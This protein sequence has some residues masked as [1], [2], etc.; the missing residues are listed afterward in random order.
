MAY[1]DHELAIIGI[2]VSILPTLLILYFDWRRRRSE[3]YTRAREWVTR[4]MSHMHG[5]V[6]L[7]TELQAQLTKKLSPNLDNIETITVGITKESHRFMI[8]KAQ[9]LFLSRDLLRPLQSAWNDLKPESRNLLQGI[10][11]F[12]FIEA[13]LFKIHTILQAFQD[14]GALTQQ[15]IK[16]WGEVNASFIA[17]LQNA[18]D[19]MKNLKNEI[20]RS[21]PIWK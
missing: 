19:A 9:D 8:N 18:I 21:L 2:Y 4:C 1:T 3:R 10:S 14:G 12:I 7:S 17:S 20:D 15:Q 6:F 13:D 16:E 5:F 11:P